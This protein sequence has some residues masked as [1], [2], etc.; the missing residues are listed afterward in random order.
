MESSKAWDNATI[1][2]IGALL[3][4][5]EMLKRS[6]AFPLLM[7]SS[8]AW[9]NATIRWI[10]GVAAF[11]GTATLLLGPIQPISF[12]GSIKRCTKSRQA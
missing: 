4:F 8:K 3:R 7:E 10:G 6:K 1:Q 9:D 11:H 5:R 12:V 2:W